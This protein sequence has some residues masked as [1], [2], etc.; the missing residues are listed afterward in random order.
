VEEDLL[1]PLMQL[2][3]PLESLIICSACGDDQELHRCTVDL[4]PDAELLLKPFLCTCYQRCGAPPYDHPQQCGRHVDDKF[5]LANDSQTVKIQNGN[6]FVSLYKS[7]DL[8]T[9][10]LAPFSRPSSTRRM[11][12]PST[13][14]HLIC[15]RR[16]YVAPMR[17]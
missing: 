16:L 17:Q 15:L 10:Q 13:E 3:W 8:Q 2:T 14:N 4:V 11:M 7:A 9:T 12:I 5:S 6:D 1:G